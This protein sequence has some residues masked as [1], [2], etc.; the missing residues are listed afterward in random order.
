MRHL[1]KDLPATLGVD[2]LRT[3]NPSADLSRALRC[4]IIVLVAGDV[5]E[6]IVAG[7]EFRSGAR[8]LYLGSEFDRQ[9][10]YRPPSSDVNADF[11]DLV[12]YSSFT[13]FAENRRGGRWSPQC[14]VPVE[15]GIVMLPKVLPE[16]HL[17]RLARWFENALRKGAHDSRWLVQ[18]QAGMDCYSE[19]HMHL[20]VKGERCTKRARRA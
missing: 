2:D 5:G 13:L 4:P 1:T 20:V 8:F 18:R 15:S 7:A 16:S 14:T 6:Q 12:F 3:R 10:L 17:P 9:R 19:L 11:V